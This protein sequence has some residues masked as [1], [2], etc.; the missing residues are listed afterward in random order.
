MDIL[1]QVSGGGLLD[2]AASG[3][4]VEIVLQRL[5]VFRGHGLPIAR[6]NLRGGINESPRVRVGAIADVHQIAFDLLQ[7]FAFGF[8]QLEK[9]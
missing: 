8:R 6:K 9:I 4:R 3:I 7:R 5:L 2:L 1:G